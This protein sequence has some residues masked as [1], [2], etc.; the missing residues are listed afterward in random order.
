MSVNLQGEILNF[1][2]GCKDC[3]RYRTRRCVHFLNVFDENIVKNICSFECC[4]KCRKMHEIEDDINKNPCMLVNDRISIQLYIITHMLDNFIYEKTLKRRK[5]LILKTIDKTIHDKKSKFAMKALMRDSEN[6][7]ILTNILQNINDWRIFRYEIYDEM[8]HYGD[9]E[10][11]GYNKKRLFCDIVCN[12]L[13]E[14]F[15]YYEDF[16]DDYLLERV[17]DLFK[18]RY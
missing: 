3:K 14:K 5:E 15:R 12:Y 4:W 7:I 8:Y 13:W 17:Q 16:F 10:F 2:F 18:V 9:D 1:D 11:R 6:I